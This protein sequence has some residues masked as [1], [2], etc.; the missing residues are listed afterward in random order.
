M[1]ENSPAITLAYQIGKREIIE[2]IAL[3]NVPSNPGQG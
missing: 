1:D 3:V 2:E